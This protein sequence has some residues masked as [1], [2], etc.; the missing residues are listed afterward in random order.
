MIKCKVNAERVSLV[1]H[2][3]SVVYI[4]EKQYELAKNF[5]EPVSERGRKSSKS[6]EDEV[7]EEK[8]VHK[9]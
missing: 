7:V 5:V 3:D 6:E 1:V 2:K 8:T 9:K 4:D